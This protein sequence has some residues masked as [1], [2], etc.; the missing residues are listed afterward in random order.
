[1]TSRDPDPWGIIAIIY[2]ALCGAL[3]VIGILLLMSHFAGPDLEPP[4]PE[5]KYF[6]L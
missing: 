4:K 2:G 5:K 3:L 6:S 1:M